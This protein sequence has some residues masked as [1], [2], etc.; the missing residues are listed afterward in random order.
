[1]TVAMPR[2]SGMRSIDGDKN[3]AK[4]KWR[5]MAKLCV[6]RIARC[7]GKV[8]IIFECKDVAVKEMFTILRTA[9]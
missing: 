2:I 9:I 7:N 3:G 6:N 5:R 8:E 1:M 4:E